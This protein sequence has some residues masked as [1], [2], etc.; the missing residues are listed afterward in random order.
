MS[1]FMFNVSA[2]SLCLY[3]PL[4][5]SFISVSFHK[6]S[7]SIPLAFSL[8]LVVCLLI[9]V[10]RLFLLFFHEREEKREGA[11]TTV[12]FVDPPLS[13]GYIDA[14]LRVP[15]SVLPDTVHAFVECR[16]QLLMN[17]TERSCCHCYWGI[18]AP[19]RKKD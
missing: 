16:I 2:L 4:Y 12:G 5:H 18:G 10:P 15:S 11:S 1:T 7:V 17:A 14:V 6:A 19:S 8:S 13:S 3:P 9:P